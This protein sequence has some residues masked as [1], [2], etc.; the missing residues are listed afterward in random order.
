MN[1]SFLTLAA[2]DRLLYSTIRENTKQVV[3]RKVRP[4]PKQHASANRRPDM[5]SVSDIAHNIISCKANHKGLTN[6]QEL[7][8][9][10]GKGRS[11][12]CSI[13]ETPNYTG[14]HTSATQHAKHLRFLVQRSQK[15][16]G[17]AALK[18]GNSHFK[19]SSFGTE[20]VKHPWSRHEIS[21]KL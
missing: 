12:T 1:F 21:S 13:A 4:F 11:I 7:P 10:S 6:F 20:V 9:P 19:G 16:M 2:L 17:R 18:S 15:P 8:D 14:L 3:S 5:D